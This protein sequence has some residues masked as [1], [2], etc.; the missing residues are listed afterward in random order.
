M[1]NNEARSFK[2]LEDIWIN[3]PDG[4]FGP[5]L[6]WVTFLDPDIL[7]ISFMWKNLI[8]QENIHLNGSIKLI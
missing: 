3:Y 2:K 1:V 5:I 4:P 8:M 6:F 7:L